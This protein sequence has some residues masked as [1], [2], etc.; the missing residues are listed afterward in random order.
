MLSKYFLWNFRTYSP[1]HISNYNNTFIL[2][3]WHFFFI[4]S[5]QSDINGSKHCLIQQFL[6][7]LYSEHRFSLYANN[8]EEQRVF[9]TKKCLPSSYQSN[10]F[11]RSKVVLSSML[12]QY[13][14]LISI[15]IK[16]L[17]EFSNDPPPHTNNIGL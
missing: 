4:H 12:F 5:L 6:D 10:I 2:H 14:M 1:I 3:D 15:K 16:V 11:T 9:P 13:L 8:K 7:K 17:V